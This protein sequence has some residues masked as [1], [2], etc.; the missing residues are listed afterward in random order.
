MSHPQKSPIE[1]VSEAEWTALPATVQ[2]VVIGLVDENRQLRLTIAKLEEQLR[3]NSRS[4]SQPPSQDKAEQKSAEDEVTRP[5]RR[6]GGQPGHVGR[7]RALVP[8][9]AVDRLVVHR[10]VQCQTWGA[11]LLGYDS[12]PRRHQIT[13]LPLVKAT[14]TEHQAHTLTCPCCG[15]INRGTLPPEVEASQFGPN[16]V[17]RMTVLMGCYRLSN[18]Q[19]VDLVGTC[20]GVPV[21]VSSVVNQQQVMSAALAQP[22]E[23]LHAYVQQQPAC[24]ID[25]TSWR[26]GE[27]TKASWLWVVVTTLV[28]VFHIVPSRSGAI[29][30]QLLGETYAGVV[31]SDRAS[32]YN[33]LDPS[34]RQLCWS[35][36]L[37]DFQKILERGGDSY[38]IG[39]NLKLH[40]AYLL[41]SWAWV[42]DGTLAYETLLAEFPAIQCHLRH[43]LTQGLLWPDKGTAETCRR[44]I[45]LDAALWSFVTA[46]G[47]EPT[48][49]AAERALRHPVIWRRTSHGTQSDH[50]RLFVQRMLTVAETCRRQHR[51]IL[52]FVRSALVAYRA[53]YPA[54]SLLPG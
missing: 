21:A 15:A 50:D 13:E 35:H 17:S 16:L 14:V 19:V 12:T 7:G 18:R 40:A 5:A 29:A 25:E 2:G 26:Q 34:Q 6:R 24:N 42:R 20:L 30:R 46:P 49:N 23:E 52:A 31:G 39:A 27:Q 37:R 36:L 43:W 10:P 22:V 32:A 45:A 38:R 3:R 4:S 9:E 33:W 48:N 44:L 11:L 8:V 47:V 51:P 53:G 41:V 28:T 54:P 1:S